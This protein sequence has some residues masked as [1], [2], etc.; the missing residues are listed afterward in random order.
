[1]N[2][3]IKELKLDRDYVTYED[4]GA[5]GDGKTEEITSTVFS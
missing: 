3:E 1:M 5:V 2:F 4:F